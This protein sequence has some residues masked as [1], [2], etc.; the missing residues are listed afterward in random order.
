MGCGVSL[1]M[2]TPTSSGQPPKPVIE[3]FRA[4]QVADLLA[5]YKR[6][7]ENFDKKMFGLRDEQLDMAF[8]PDA[9]VGRWPIRRVHGS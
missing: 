9:G 5:R 2:S 3:E 7:V 4:M 6:G 1:G 8:L